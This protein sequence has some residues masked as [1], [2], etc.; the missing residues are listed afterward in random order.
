MIQWFIFLLDMSFSKLS[1]K[2][3]IIAMISQISSSSGSELALFSYQY[4]YH[5]RYWF[6]FSNS[7]GIRHHIGIILVSVLIFSLLSVSVEHYW[8]N[9][10]LLFEILYSH[11][12]NLTTSLFLIHLNRFTWTTPIEVLY[13]R[14]FTSILARADGFPAVGVRAVDYW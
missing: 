13:M 6:G 2:S 3:N 1:S 7:I 8:P 5:Y 14:Y 4:Q 12:F 11:C 9:L 10:T